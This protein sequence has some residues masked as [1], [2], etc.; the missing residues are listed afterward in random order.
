MDS[1]GHMQLWADSPASWGGAHIG[2][3]QD[4]MR[5]PA[6]RAVCALRWRIS[7]S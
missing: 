2:D 6:W 3:P 4:R 1:P 5:A 7:G